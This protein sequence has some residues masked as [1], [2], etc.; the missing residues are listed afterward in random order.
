MMKAVSQGSL[1]AHAICFALIVTA[2]FANPYSEA[3]ASLYPTDYVYLDIDGNPL[4]FQDHATILEV[5]RT[6]P[7]VDQKLMSRGIAANIKLVLEHEG[8]RFHAVLRMV[9]LMEK[10]KT[11]SKR[12]VVK[13][14]D[15]YIFEVAAYELDQMLGIGRVPPTVVRT[16]EGHTGSVQ[17]WMEGT[18][19]EDLM[20]EQGRLN[21]PDTIGWFK[22]KTVMW[23][24]DALV[25]NVDRNQGNLLI[26]SDWNL[27]FIDHTRAFRETP[28]LIDVEAISTCERGLWAAIQAIDDE[29]LEKRLKDYLTSNELKKLFLR[30]KNLVKHITKKI[31]K[32]GEDK[33]LYDM[34]P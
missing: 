32:H 15:S 21:P 1:R 6:A 34:R 19:P 2:F 8:V 3:Q 11:G 17:I 5:L 33:V 22:Q 13:Y 26:D 20:V 16:V 29:A 4:P 28:S 25:A 30:R 24:F 10:E 23:V 31:R 12:M 7:V 27:W 14:R 9:D 18:T